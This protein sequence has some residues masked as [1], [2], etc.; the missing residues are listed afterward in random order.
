MENTSQSKEETDNTDREDR[1]GYFWYKK[2]QDLR[3]ISF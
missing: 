2:N 1:A 3:T